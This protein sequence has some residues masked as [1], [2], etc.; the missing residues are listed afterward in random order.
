MMQQYCD[1][2]WG[3]DSNTDQ[4]WP[5]YWQKVNCV[6]KR[7]LVKNLC[8]STLIGSFC[9]NFNFPWRFYEVSQSY[10]HRGLIVKQIVYSDWLIYTCYLFLH[11]ST[12]KVFAWTRKFETIG[13]N[14]SGFTPCA[15]LRPITLAFTQN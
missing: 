15:K 8:G 4:G 11:I 6:R 13:F 10:F 7:H 12:I 14:T 3:E 1:D 9:C 5:Q 2:I